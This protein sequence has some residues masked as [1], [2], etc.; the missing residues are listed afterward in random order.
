M[1]NKRIAQAKRNNKGKIIE[2]FEHKDSSLIDTK[3]IKNM[4][5]KS[6]INNIAKNS[7]F[8]QRQRKLNAYDFFYP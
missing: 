3:A 5:R 6:V 1:P 8:I 7:R 4:F 2:H